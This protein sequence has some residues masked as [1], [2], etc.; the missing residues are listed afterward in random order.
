[1]KKERE[2]KPG[3]S[4]VVDVSII[5]VSHNG[6]DETCKMIESIQRHVHSVTYEI[7]V[8]DNASLRNDIPIL[9]KKYPSEFCVVMKKL[10]MQVGII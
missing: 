1:M 7:I 8:V 9:R 5:T 4:R 6:F 2:T 3:K 10:I